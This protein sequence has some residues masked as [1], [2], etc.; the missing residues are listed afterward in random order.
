LRV[1]TAVTELEWFALVWLAV[2]GGCVG[3]FL[4]V[5]IHR[6]PKSQSLLGRSQCPKC[7]HQIRA[8]HNVPVLAWLVLRGKCCDCGAKISIRYPAVEAVTAAVFAG[9][10]FV[11][12]RQQADDVFD[13][14]FW[15]IYKSFVVFVC[16]E[17]CIML[18]LADRNRVPRVLFFVS[19]VSA[20]TLVIGTIAI[21][22]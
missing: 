8:F 11:L 21:P 4:N 6:L 22:K 17:M 2:M 10:F 7:Q 20:V 9:L 19:I 1:E 15:L 12:Y 3:S 5:V 18:I 16:S 13:P 14:R